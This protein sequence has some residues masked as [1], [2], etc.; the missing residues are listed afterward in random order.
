[1]KKFE[2]EENLSLAGKGK[3]KANKGPSNGSTSKVEKEIKCFACH[4]PWHFTRQCHNKKKGKQKKE[5]ATTTEVDE[6]ATKFKDEF[7]LIAYLLSSIAT[8]MWYVNSGA[9]FHMTRVKEY[10]TSLKEKEMNST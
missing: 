4:R 7:S 3:M 9:Y 2:D 6:F 1:M 5:V 10:F 8:N